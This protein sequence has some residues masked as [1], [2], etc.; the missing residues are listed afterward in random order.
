MRLDRRSKGFPNGSRG[1]MPNGQGSAVSSMSWKSPSVLTR[2]GG[3]ADTTKAPRRGRFAR[4]A[5]AATGWSRGG[6]G[7]EVVSSLF[8]PLSF[9]HWFESAG[10]AATLQRYTEAVRPDRHPEFS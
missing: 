9:R 8:P 10:T 6:G 4:P 3:K 1:S 2:F 7:Q 5:P